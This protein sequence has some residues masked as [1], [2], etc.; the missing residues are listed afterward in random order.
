MRPQ[1]QFPHLNRFKEK[2]E[3]TDETIFAWNGEI[4]CDFE[5]SPALYAH[6]FT[7]H[8]QQ[9]IIG[10]EVWLEN[11]LNDPKF[12]L[13]QELEAY[14]VQLKVI[15]DKNWKH[16]EMLLCAKSLSSKLYGGLLSEAEARKILC[17]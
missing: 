8:K 15:K 9:D 12:R 4:F 6:E 13:E 5:L 1:N 16:K 10:K 2:F 11:Y 3:V 14:K 7:H 17:D